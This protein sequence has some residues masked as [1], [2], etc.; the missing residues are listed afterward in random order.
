MQNRP[1]SGRNSERMASLD[2]GSNSFRMWVAELD[3]QGR[4]HQIANFKHPVRLAAGVGPDGTLSEEAAARALGVIREFAGIIR[5][6]NVRALR[7]IATSTF[8]VASNAADLLVSA[9]EILSVPVEVVSGLEEARLIYK[10]ASRQLP[11]DGQDRLVIDIGGGST[12]CIIGNNGRAKL[13]DSAVIGCVAL[14]KQFFPAGKV[15]AAAMD[16]A[17]FRARD[18]F[19]PIVAPTP[20][21]T[22]WW[23]FFRRSWN[24]SGRIR[25]IGC[26]MRS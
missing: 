22:A 18:Y 12:E 24:K 16:D 25:R 10:G 13:V 3:D 19:A 8:R 7:A 26:V 14:S 5:D 17:L 15:T 1:S 9:E 4:L 20:P 6:M 21:T 11:N 2:L 23:R